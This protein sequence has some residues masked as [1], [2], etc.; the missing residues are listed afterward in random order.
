MGSDTQSNCAS[1]L[2]TPG[3]GTTQPG[4]APRA[5]SLIKRFELANC[6]SAHPAWPILPLWKPQSRLSP[7][8]SS[9]SVCFLTDTGASPCGPPWHGTTPPLGI[10]EYSSISFQGQLSPKLLASPYLKKSKI[11]ILKPSR[12]P[13]THS[14]IYTP[15]NA[16]FT[17]MSLF[18]LGLNRAESA[19]TPT[20][21][22]T[23]R[24]E[25]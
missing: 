10:Y 15:W 18:V 21:A 20:G 4:T 19:T 6:K 17:I 8:L 11:Y 1:V 3:L 7:M 5:Q 22:F 24:F 12:K 2:I 23:A 13:Q 14:M 25:Q 16:R 9:C